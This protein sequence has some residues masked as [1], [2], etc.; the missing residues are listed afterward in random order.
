M[1]RDDL[2]TCWPWAGTPQGRAQQRKRVDALAEYLH[3]GGE[4]L[5]AE[6]VAR[7]LGVHRRTVQRWRRALEEARS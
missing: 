4:G 5:P 6:V 3:I 2:E 1:T 7:R